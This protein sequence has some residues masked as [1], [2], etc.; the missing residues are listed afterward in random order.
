MMLSRVKDQLSKTMQD[1]KEDNYYPTLILTAAGA[2][3]L[4]RLM[5]FIK[6]R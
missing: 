5:G 6:R 2:F 4:G 3:V 1:P